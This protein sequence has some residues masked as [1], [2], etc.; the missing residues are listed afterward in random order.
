MNDSTPQIENIL[1]EMATLVRDA[2]RENESIDQ[3]RVNQLAKAL[4][5]NGWERHNTDG[6]PLLI[7]IKDEY[8]SFLV[9]QR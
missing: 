3:E 4:S 1:T 2:L 5:S 6:P 8:V 7:Q 9:L